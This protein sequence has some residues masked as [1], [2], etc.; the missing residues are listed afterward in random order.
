MIR[1]SPGLYILFFSIIVLSYTGKLLYDGS[2]ENNGS[3]YTL[4]HGKK[5]RD[6]EEAIRLRRLSSREAVF[7]HNE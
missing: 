7:Y 2:G 1:L 5:N 6:I 3:T 4:Y